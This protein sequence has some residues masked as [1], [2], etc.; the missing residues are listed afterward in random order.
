MEAQAM[1]S[2]TTGQI[3]TENRK[4]YKSLVGGQNFQLLMISTGIQILLSVIIHGAAGILSQVF[5]AL[6]LLGLFFAR[7]EQKRGVSLVKI[8]AAIQF[9]IY[10]VFVGLLVFVGI[11]LPISGNMPDAIPVILVGML[12]GSAGFILGGL[13]FRAVMKTTGDVLTW[14]EQP[15]E[16][17]RTTYHLQL[18]SWIQVALGSI[19]VVAT[20][21]MSIAVSDMA[22]LIGIIADFGGEEAEGIQRVLGLFL[23]ST[24][25]LEIIHGIAGVVR[26]V[27]VA[28]LADQYLAVRPQLPSPSESQKT[29]TQEKPTPEPPKKRETAEKSVMIILTPVDG[30][31]KKMSCDLGTDEHG[32]VLGRNPSHADWL[33]TDSSISGRHCRLAIRDRRLCVEDLGSSNGTK[34]NGK[35]VS[36]W[37]HVHRKDILTLGR[38]EYTV[39]WVLRNGRKGE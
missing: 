17:N 20:V 5:P 3:R 26:Y 7:G 19:T 9:W 28:L 32:I 2:E 14:F 10:A 11:Y 39:N 36:G 25:V 13:Y 6:S 34:V 23:P 24:G 29:V 4:A 37:V 8:C 15:M 22:S 35:K 31:E 12:I 33:F 30:N 21:I 27:S 38:K 16:T 1:G 18:Y